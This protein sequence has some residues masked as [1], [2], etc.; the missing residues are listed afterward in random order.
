MNEA[1]DEVRHELLIHL[2]MIANS[3]DRLATLVD[4]ST[5]KSEGELQEDA[6]E[7]EKL[8]E[9]SRDRARAA[10][11]DLR[12]LIEEE[13]RE[14]SDDLISWKMTGQTYKLHARADRNE[15]CATTA[16]ELAVLAMDEVERAILRALLARK[17]AVSAQMQRPG[18]LAQVIAPAAGRSD[19]MSL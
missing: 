6:V 18:E 12:R 4:K 2:S 13:R 11:L 8:V 10:R 5:S 1:I 15:C 3:V 7:F 17:E 14:A 9:Q 19:Y 16:I